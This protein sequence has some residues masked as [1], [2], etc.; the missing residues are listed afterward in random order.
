MLKLA[1]SSAVVALLTGCAITASAQTPGPWPGSPSQAFSTIHGNAVNSSEAL[2]PYATVRLR[3]IRSGRIADV[4]TSDKAGAFAFRGVDPGS[5]I[6]ELMGNNE[7]TVATSQILDLNAGQSASVV[8]KLPAQA[9]R[10]IALL[11]HTTPSLLAVT[12]AAAAS[13]VLASAVTGQ[14]VSPVQ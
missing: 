12:S 4:T 7:T 3:D 13:G 10:L 6:I 11:G 1:L 9:S 8:V 14:P 2:L 5:Y